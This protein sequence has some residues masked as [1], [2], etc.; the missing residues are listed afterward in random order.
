MTLRGIKTAVFP[1]FLAVRATGPKRQLTL[2]GIKTSLVDSP[3][4]L[5]H[6]IGPKRQL[7]LRG[8]K[9]F[10]PSVSNT[11]T[12]SSEEAVDPERD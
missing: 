8:I 1:G 5:P 7:T 4:R 12:G 9:T 2:R 3:I 11:L 10:T 6:H